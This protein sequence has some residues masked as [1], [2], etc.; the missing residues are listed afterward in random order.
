MFRDIDA[1]ELSDR[2]SQL[3]VWRSHGNQ[4][5]MLETYGESGFEV[6]WGGVLIRGRRC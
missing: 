5:D 3:L 4:T 6:F 2:D 1:V